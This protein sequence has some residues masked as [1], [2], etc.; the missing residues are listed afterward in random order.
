MQIDIPTCSIHPKPKIKVWFV[1]SRSRR[2]IEYWTLD[3]KAAHSQGRW[4]V[5]DVW[6]EEIDP[7]EL[8]AIKAHAEEAINVEEAI[9]L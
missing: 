4:F 1:G 8:E 7:T 3:E 5:G 2:Q 9:G 6:A